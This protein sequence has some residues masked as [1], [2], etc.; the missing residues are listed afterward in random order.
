MALQ[1]VDLG[2]KLAEHVLDPDQVLFGGMQSQLGLVAAGVQSRNA[3]R[4]LEHPAAL[5]GFGL[6]DLADAPLMNERGRTRAR[7]GIRK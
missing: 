5:L 7:G 2:R 4:F 1:G 6:D 3:G